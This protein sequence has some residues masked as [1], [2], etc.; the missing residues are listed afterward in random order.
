MD[1]VLLPWVPV[2]QGAPPRVAF[3][4]L[5]ETPRRGGAA[6]HA[7][8]T[9]TEATRNER[10]LAM[11]GEAS[12]VVAVVLLTGL[13]IGLPG[14]GQAAGDEDDAA[15]AAM[16]LDGAARLEQLFRVEWVASPGRSARSRLEG[17]VH[18]DHGR[19]ALSVQPARRT[20][21]SVAGNE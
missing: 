6:L 9:N 13:A 2:R 15:A 17:S 19:T 16:V 14:M 12:R 4:T 1:A 5:A 21:G 3:R 11:R 18:N 10:S 7:L 20:V 8:V